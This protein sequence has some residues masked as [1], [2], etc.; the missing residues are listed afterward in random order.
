[1]NY[2]RADKVAAALKKR[3]SQIIQTELKDPRIGFVTITEVK[4]SRDLEHVK[5]Y[6]SVLG[7]EKQKKSAIIGLERATSFVRRLIAT[8]MRFRFVPHI[9]FKFDETYEYG[10]H[11]NELLERVKRE[12][13]ERNERDKKSNRRIKEA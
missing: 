3:I 11:I 8:E 2:N 13:E 9:V 12:E 1:M 6:F 10:Q 5:V 7:N 4:V